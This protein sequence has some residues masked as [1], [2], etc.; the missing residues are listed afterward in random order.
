M[1]RMANKVTTREIKERSGVNTETN[2]SMVR[3]RRGMPEP[4]LKGKEIRKK[5]GK[6]SNLI[7]T[8]RPPLKGQAYINTLPSSKSQKKKR[9]VNHKQ[10]EKTGELNAERSLKKLAILLLNEDLTFY[11]AYRRVGPKKKKREK[12]KDISSTPVEPKS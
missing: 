8:E 12:E 6:R 3:N 1:R 10:K 2:H 4:K 5:L 9:R 11:D 7:A